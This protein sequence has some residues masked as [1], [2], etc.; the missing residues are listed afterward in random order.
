MP[1]TNL[2]LVVTLSAHR[3][4]VTSLA[5]ARDD[6]T[7]ASGGK[8]TEI[9][10]WDLVREACQHRLK[11]HKDIIHDIVW[12]ERLRMIVS[13]SQDSHV[14]VWDVETYH[15]LQTIVDS[16]QPICAL[17][18][19]P[20]ES[21][22]FVGSAE[23]HLRMYRLL[24]QPEHFVDSVAVLEGELSRSTTER[25]QTIAVGWNG[26]Y[27][28]CQVAG[29]SVDVWQK[30]T[31]DQIK[32]KERKR[33]KKEKEREKEKGA[34]EKGAKEAVSVPLT[35]ADH[36]RRVST[37]KS[38]VRCRSAIFLPE[39]ACVGGEP[40]MLVSLTNNSLQLYKL[41]S[42]AD[43][44][45]AAGSHSALVAQLLMTLDFSGHRSDIRSIAMVEENDGIITASSDGIRCWR[46]DSGNCIR[47]VLD[48]GYVLNVVSLPGGNHAI[49]STKTGDI[50][51]IDVQSGRMLESAMAA[52]TGAVWSLALDPTGD[53]FASGGADKTVKF[54][55]FELVT[56]D[57]VPTASNKLSFS[58]SRE[59][60][61][62]DDVLAL[63][64][65]PIIAD[66]QPTIAVAT[67]DATVKIF[68]VDTLKLFL[69]LYGHKLPVV[70][71]DI[72]SDGTLLATGSSDKNIKIWGLEFGDLH[73]SIFAHD[74]AVMQV[75]WQ[76]STH[77]LFSASKDKTL[78]YWDMDTFELVQVLEGHLS[79]VWGL[80]VSKNGEVVISCGRDRS[81][82]LWERTDEI[83]ILDEEKENRLE[84]LLESTD[85]THKDAVS[86]K[87][88]TDE[89]LTLCDRLIEALDIVD[90]EAEKDAL[91]A[92]ELRI[93]GDSVRPAPH[94]ILQGRTPAQYLL[95]T[96][97][98]IPSSDIEDVLMVLPF[99]YAMRLLRSLH[100]LL[101]TPLFGALEMVIRALLF[102]FRVHQ[103]QII[104]G[105]LLSD[106][107]S[108]LRQDVRN[109]IQQRLDELGLNTESLSLIK[110]HAQRNNSTEL[111]NFEEK[112][113]EVRERSAK[114]PVEED[115]S[116]KSKKPGSSKKKKKRL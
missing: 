71:L 12:V 44:Q 77:Y 42:S 40:I 70:C 19:N 32:H 69:N 34:K 22:L 51:L 14:R 24:E 16:T 72:S 60:E 38:V 26:S 83:L 4:A 81:I 21:L 67:L 6:C 54:W 2:S 64:Y 103:Y 79:E 113:A 47:S 105:G 23:K 111:F 53:G 90:E 10:L 13:A 50:H 114:R 18:L 66:S 110:H 57:A 62:Q 8:D 1:C 76:P 3:S 75:C 58:L 31:E 84:K 33:R 39:S 85:S 36:Y 74:D 52:H 82:R 35:L 108:T 109:A 25:P 115:T 43:V 17:G 107:V 116:R 15:C 46:A 73:R 78:K 49:V 91:H 68:Y 27:I 102:V 88:V 92:E 45:K 95:K 86:S 20:D 9:A 65:A 55:S 48:A 100:L 61:L 96:M 29:K 41:T 94:I 30:L 104:H 59:M 93:S 98:D 97:R 101:A 11:G 99:S 28:A 89:S 5:F 106:E 7:L 80:A 63:K 37:L 112:L 56:D 87:S